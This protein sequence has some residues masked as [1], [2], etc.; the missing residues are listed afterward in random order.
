[1]RSKTISLESELIQLRP[2]IQE[3][4]FMKLLWGQL[5]NP[6]QV[7][8]ALNTEFTS[9]HYAVLIVHYEANNKKAFGSDDVTYLRIH[10]FLERHLSFVPYARVICLETDAV[11]LTVL[12]NFKE[13][14]PILDIRSLL[15][16]LSKQFRTQISQELHVQAITGFGPYCKS[17]EELPGAYLEAQR[18]V[19]FK[20]FQKADELPD[21]DEDLL[22]LYAEPIRNL[23]EELVHGEPNCVRAAL[24]ELITVLR[25]NL[26]S[27]TQFQIQQIVVHLLNIVGEVLIRNKLPLSD[28][29][30]EKRNL[31]SELKDLDELRSIHHW[32][33]S[34]CLTAAESIAQNNARQANRNIRRILEYIDQHLQEDISLN[35]ISDWI[36]LSPSY[37]SRLFKEITGRNFVEYLSISRVEQAKLLLQNTQLPIKEVGFKSGLTVCRRLF[38]PLKRLPD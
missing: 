19:R 37:I 31:F 3:R 14:M 11:T 17:L 13:P 32:L 4:F 7:L 15:L 9:S 25:N 12:L 35:D 22:L 38:V 24:E 30:G 20:L 33:E 16:S 29:F 1:M 27:L 8:A 18:A 2:I 5:E 26:S 36:G 28:V 34:I 6:A 21:E 10:S 23:E